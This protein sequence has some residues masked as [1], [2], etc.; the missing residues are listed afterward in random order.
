MASVI[1]FLGSVIFETEGGPP[2]RVPISEVVQR[3]YASRAKCAWMSVA[4]HAVVS[5][6][7]A[8]MQRSTIRIR[9]SDRSNRDHE[10]YLWNVRPNPNQNH[11]EFITRL[12]DQMFFGW[13]KG[14]A[15]VVP[16]RDS[17]WI[18]DGWT[19]N[20]EP[21]RPSRFENVSI[22]GSTEVGKRSYS[23]NEVFLFRLAET[24]R[25]RYL[26]AQMEAAYDEM[27]T[28]S[29]DAF[30]DKN[31]R[32]Y[33]LHVD[34]Q[35]AGP[36]STVERVNEYLKDSVSPFIQGTD[37]ALPLFRGFELSR[38]ESDYSGGETTLDVVQIRQE[39]FKVVATCLGIPYSFL[40]GN[41]N[42]FESVFD[43]V[44]TFL[45]DPVAKAIEDEIAAKSLSER[46]Y[47]KGGEVRVDTTHIRHV[48]LLNVADKL[49]KLVGSSIS[50]PNELRVLTGQEPA[51]APGMDDYHMTLNHSVL[52]T[53][54]GSEGGDNDENSNA[55]GGK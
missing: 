7:I 29:I 9:G 35:Q 38:M 28:S 16:A 12:L 3:A 2:E 21:G 1:D 22:E 43:S 25:W 37:V 47:A 19:E 17:L 30:G 24:S 45:I 55:D 31:D 20:K 14:S 53:T 34:Q 36:S 10:D 6:V 27:A 23:A 52:G 4:Y 51:D 46:E 42:N 41:V 39:C 13:R 49:E 44:L 33:L 54:T 11:T 8:G 5:Y 48:D 40:E 18:A 15:L 50:T 26:F 32:R